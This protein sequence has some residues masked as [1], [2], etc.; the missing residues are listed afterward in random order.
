MIQVEVGARL[1]RQSRK[2]ISAV[3]LVV[4]LFARQ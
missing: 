3:A 4:G 2:A 1:V